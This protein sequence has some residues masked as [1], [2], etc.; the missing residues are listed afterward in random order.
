MRFELGNLAL[1]VNID[2]IGPNGRAAN[3][4]AY[5]RIDYSDGSQ[6][7]LGV[8]CHGPGAPDG[9]AEGINATKGVVTYTAVGAPAPGVDL[10]RTTFHI[11]N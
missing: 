8:F 2:K 1:P 10:N 9:I 5:L 7:V 11:L 4:W 6:G 3:G